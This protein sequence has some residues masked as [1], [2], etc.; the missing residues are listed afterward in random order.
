MKRKG[1]LLSS[2]LNQVK[3]KFMNYGQNTRTRPLEPECA[4]QALDSAHKAAQLLAAESSIA[5]HDQRTQII[6]ASA[7][8]SAHIR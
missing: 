1:S 2:R 7:E 4:R 6:A 3:S 8:P 5:L